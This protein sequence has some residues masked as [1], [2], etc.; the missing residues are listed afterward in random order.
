MAGVHKS[1]LA[2][3]N[4]EFATPALEVMIGTVIGHVA[5]AFI[6]AFVRRADCVCAASA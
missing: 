3:L 1:V 4:D 5:N 2:P 6:D